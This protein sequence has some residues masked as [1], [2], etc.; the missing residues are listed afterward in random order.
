MQGLVAVVKKR[1]YPA[2]NFENHGGIILPGNPRRVETPDAYGVLFVIQFQHGRYKGPSRPKSPEFNP[3]RAQRVTSFLRG[4]LR[5]TTVQEFPKSDASMVVDILFGQ[6]IDTHV[7]QQA[8]V[9][10]I[11]SAES[12]LQ[13]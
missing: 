9:S 12:E 4:C 1:T 7:L 3:Q 13:H 2:P 10:L 11:R 8:Y 5:T 6:Y